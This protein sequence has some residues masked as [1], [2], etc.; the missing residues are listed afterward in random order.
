MSDE[1]KRLWEQGAKELFYR[2]A[3][4][5]KELKDLQGNSDPASAGRFDELIDEL[6]TVDS[7]LGPFRNAMGNAP[8]KQEPEKPSAQERQS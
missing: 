4:I 6:M 3:A 7:A 2:R 5:E 1:V 8:K